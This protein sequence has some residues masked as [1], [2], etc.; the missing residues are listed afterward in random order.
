MSTCTNVR[1]GRL[2]SSRYCHLVLN[3]A[4][5]S[6]FEPVVDVNTDN[7]LQLSFL[8]ARLHHLWPYFPLAKV[9]LWLFPAV[10]SELWR[11][12]GSHK[13]AKNGAK[14]LPQELFNWK[15]KDLVSTSCYYFFF[16]YFLNLAPATWH[17][18]ETWVRHSARYFPV[19]YVCTWWKVTF[20]TL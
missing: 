16:F 5:I 2:L 4:N 18:D 20:N 3:N 7:S 17:D 9:L 14:F 13:K 12:F 19:S 1:E 15:D 11:L 10:P 8:T 6:E